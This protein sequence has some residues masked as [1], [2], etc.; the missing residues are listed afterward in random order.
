MSKNLQETEQQLTMAQSE[1]V[2][3]Q[4]DVDAMKAR[5]A[6]LE[7]ANYNDLKIDDLKAL[8]TSKGIEF[9]SG[10]LKDELITLLQG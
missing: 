6:V 8:L 1:F 2:T 9:K 4:N 7:S 5:V 10:A 3:F